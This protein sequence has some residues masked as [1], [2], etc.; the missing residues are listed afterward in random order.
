MRNSI[1]IKSRIEYAMT[2]FSAYDF[3]IMAISIAKFNI[4]DKSADK[5]DQIK[6]SK[7][8]GTAV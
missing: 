5:G 6:D 4:Y 7:L 8:E 3:L 1:V 2:E